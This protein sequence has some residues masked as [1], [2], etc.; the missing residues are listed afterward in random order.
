MAEIE[1]TPPAG[2][3]LPH[4]K[5]VGDTF[6]AVAQLRIEDGGKL[7]LEALNGVSIEGDDDGEDDTK[8]DSS[9]EPDFLTAV[10]RGAAQQQQ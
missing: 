5:K 10:E 6:E 3:Q 8:D 9:S 1:F 2:L 7:C 4:G